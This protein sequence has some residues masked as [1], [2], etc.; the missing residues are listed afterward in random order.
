MAP[1][2]ARVLVLCTLEDKSLSTDA[3]AKMFARADVLYAEA[4][5]KAPNKRYVHASRATALYCRGDY[6]ESWKAVKEA[7][8]HGG[9]L[10]QRFL[11]LL[12][13]KM[14]EPQ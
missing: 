4:L 2:A 14:P 6:A 8:A 10:P 13:E 11:Q 7:R 3:E 5:L 9:R 12:S 1:D